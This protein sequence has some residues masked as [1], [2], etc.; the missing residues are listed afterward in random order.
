[1]TTSDPFDAGRRTEEQG[2]AA[3]IPDVRGRHTR[4]DTARRGPAMTQQDTDDLATV[5][6]LVIVSEFNAEE[7]RD[8]T[9]MGRDNV[10]AAIEHL[11]ERDLIR[12]S[13]REYY[14]VSQSSCAGSCTLKGHEMRGQEVVIDAKTLAWSCAACWDTEVERKRASM[15]EGPLAELFR[16]TEAARRQQGDDDAGC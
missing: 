6:A 1:M 5:L 12:D 13:G 2:R 11:R 3:W 16:A 10:V 9:G 14:R 15:C 4:R 8:R 7:I